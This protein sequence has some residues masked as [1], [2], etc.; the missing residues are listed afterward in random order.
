MS[1]FAIE[2]KFQS[3][4][5]EFIYN[6][7][8]NKGHCTLP[9][10]VSRCMFLSGHAK[11]LY[12]IIISYAY[13]KKEC[14][15]TQSTLCVRMG[16]I[17]KSTLR[18]YIDELEF[19]N[20]IECKTNQ[21]RRNIVYT[22]NEINNSSVIYHSEVLQ[23]LLVD[24]GIKGDQELKFL[25]HYKKCDLF[26]RINYDGFSMSFLDDIK[27]E[28]LEFIGGAEEPEKEEVIEPLDP[29]LSMLKNNVMVDQKD[30]VIGDSIEPRKKDNS[31]KMTHVM[32]EY[33]QDK[34]FNTFG[35]GYTKT[36]AD[37]KS[38]LRI[39][40]SKNNPDHIKKMIDV[41]IE[42]KQGIFQK[43]SI[44]DFINSKNQSLLDSYIMYGK[45][46]DYITKENKKGK[47]CS[48]LLN[49]E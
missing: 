11:V 42:N 47:N 41:F 14:Y 38:L 28:I 44:L 17:E 13:N 37:R 36:E 29:R 12:T 31:S 9:H 45:Y 46:P 5:K 23:S 19:S 10:K 2:F 30:I 27:N 32:L 40:K 33:F 48:L 18:N 25:K 7:G 15:P 8:V 22:I 4:E 6:E 24:N 26:H 16:G 49:E 39:V 20:L 3:S 35:F 34:F 1:D 43:I 21:S